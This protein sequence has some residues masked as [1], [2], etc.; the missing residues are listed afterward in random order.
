MIMSKQIPLAPKSATQKK[1]EALLQAER[2][3]TTALFAAKKEQY[4]MN[5]LNG[6]LA[7]PNFQFY[8]LDKGVKELIDKAFDLADYQMEK[9][10]KHVGE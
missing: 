8:D 4:A 5:I 7:N 3:R 2:A 1:N 9:M 10:Y 6:L